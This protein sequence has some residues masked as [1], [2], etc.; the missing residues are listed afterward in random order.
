MVGQTVPFV[1]GSDVTSVGTII[2][3]VQY[4]D[5]GIIL[6]VTPHINPDGLVILDVYPEVSSLTD[7]T[8]TIQAGVSAPVFDK[9]SALSRVGIKDGQTIIIGGLMQDQLSK[10]V[11][12]IPLLGDIPYLGAVFS[13]TTQTK[14]KTELLIFLTPHVALQ[15]GQLKDMSQQEKA[16]TILT[17]NAVGP[18]VFD[19]HLRGMER[20]STTQ[21]YAPRPSVVEPA[22]SQPSNS[23]P[24][25]QPA[26]PPPAPEPQP[27]EPATNG[28][29][30]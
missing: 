5:I 30:E 22:A 21:P 29:H 20:G 3:S 2:N 14:V 18:G 25:V 19:E 24:V 13:H 11:N 26:E 17:P 23:A 15:P 6:N 8:V 7:Q 10:T 9:R 1:T 4:K 27:M 28:P 16:G 12:K